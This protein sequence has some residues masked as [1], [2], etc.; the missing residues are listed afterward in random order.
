MALQT[1]ISTPLL[2]KIV[3]MHQSLS[4][5]LAHNFPRVNRQ[6]L[7]GAHVVARLAGWMTLF[8]AIPSHWY[9][10]C[11]TRSLSLS[12]V[13]I[14]PP[15]GPC[16]CERLCPTKLSRIPT[17]YLQ[18]SHGAAFM[19][20]KSSLSFYTCYAVFY[21]PPPPPSPFRSFFFVLARW[22]DMMCWEYF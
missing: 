1:C 16:Q 19:P 7:E 18:P 8:G 14:C 22:D 4:L 21:P 12:F 5:L 13:C 10:K 11:F 9:A 15:G 3:H 17:L 6:H 2:L 20:L